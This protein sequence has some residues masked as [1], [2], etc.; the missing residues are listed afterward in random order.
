MLLASEFPPPYACSYDQLAVRYTQSTQSPRLP[1]PRPTELQ[2]RSI[3]NLLDP[4]PQLP[5]LSPQKRLTH[6]L[7]AN[8][9]STQNNLHPLDLV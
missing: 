5:P 1:T 2:P 3:G 6:S 9:E 8:S 7:S 4:I